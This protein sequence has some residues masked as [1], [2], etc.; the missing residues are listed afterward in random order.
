MSPVPAL[1]FAFWIFELGQAGF[2]DF[3][4]V[5]LKP[6]AG[7]WVFLRGFFALNLFSEPALED[8][9]AWFLEE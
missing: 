5:S 2:L 4:P 3:G 1:R 6:A 9:L 8:F 7:N